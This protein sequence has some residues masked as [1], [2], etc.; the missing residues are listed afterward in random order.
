[1]HV[2]GAK[3]GKTRTTKARLV[4]VWL[5]IGWENGASFANQSQS[6]GKQNKSKRAITFDTQLTTALKGMELCL[7]FQE[8]GREEN[9]LSCEQAFY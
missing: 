3:R 9:L 4:L 6:V 7:A 8:P 1:M 5:P 2:T